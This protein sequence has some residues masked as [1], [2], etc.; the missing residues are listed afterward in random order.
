[1]RCASVTVS[2]GGE[3]IGIVPEAEVGGASDGGAE[4]ATEGTESDCNAQ[5]EAAEA[6]VVAV[7]EGAM[8]ALEAALQVMVSTA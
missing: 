8:A 6:T 3:A 1:M 4:A 5:A 7:A 2:R